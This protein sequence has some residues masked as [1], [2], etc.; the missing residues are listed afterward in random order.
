[1][2]TTKAFILLINIILFELLIKCLSKPIETNEINNN[3]VNNQLDDNNW[4]SR[5]VSNL[6]GYGLILFPTLLIVFLVKNDLCIKS[7]IYLF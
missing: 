7:G 2:F 4:L 1:M 3:V 6:L 5:L